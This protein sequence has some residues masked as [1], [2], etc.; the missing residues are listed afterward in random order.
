MVMLDADVV[1]C[2]QTSLNS[3]SDLD[4]VRTG[5]LRDCLG[6]LERVLPQLSEPEEASYHAGLQDLAASVASAQR[7]RP[8][9]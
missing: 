7:A 4:T 6:D 2:V 8:Q 1:S 3:S 5:V 9:R